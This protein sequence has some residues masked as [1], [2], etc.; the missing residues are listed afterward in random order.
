[1]LKSQNEY[2][3]SEWRRFAVVFGIPSVMLALGIIFTESAVNILTGHLSIRG[4]LIWLAAL[5]AAILWLFSRYRNSYTA[6]TRA[7]TDP[8]DQATST[9]LANK[10]ALIVVMGLDSADPGSPL[11]ALLSRFPTLDYLILLGTPE[12]KALGVSSRVTHQLLAA[13]GHN[14]PA[15]HLWVLEQAESHSLT[16]FELATRQAITW[17]LRHGVEVDQIVC[18][19]TGGKRAMGFGVLTA[20]DRAGVETH[21]LSAR[22]DHLAKR[23]IP[24]SATWQV[25]RDMHTAPQ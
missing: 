18:D 11:A 2:V 25:A 14:L 22:W 15:D 12:T 23:P 19:V 5:A 13:S 3:R 8:S 1:V 6:A 4:D 10:R 7:N 17:L 20:A 24:G 21:Y 16:D 9:R